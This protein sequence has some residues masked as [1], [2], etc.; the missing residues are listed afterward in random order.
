MLISCEY[1]LIENFEFKLIRPIATATSCINASFIIA[2]SKKLNL[3]FDAFDTEHSRFGGCLSQIG[4]KCVSMYCGSGGV[5][6]RGTYCS[7]GAIDQ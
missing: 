3:L 5:W 4:I 2:D 1:F 7:G 6:R